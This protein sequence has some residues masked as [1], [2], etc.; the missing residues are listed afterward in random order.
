MPG[1]NVLVIHSAADLYGASK[2]LVR[3]LVAFQKIDWNPITILPNE[4][5]LVQEIK[6][7][8]LE[9]IILDHGVI[10]RQ[11]LSLKGI[12]ALLRQLA[13]SFKILNRLM[14]ERGVSLIYTNSN[15]NVV[16]GLLSRWTNTK[17]IWHVHEII[18][19]PKWFKVAL[20]LYNRFFGDMLLCVSQAVIDNHPLTPKSKL[21]LLYNGIDTRPFLKTASNLKQELGLKENVILIGMVARVSFWKGQKYFLDVASVL[22]KSNPNLHFIMVG[23][24]FT[25]Y[26]YLYEENR[27][28]L[29]KLGLKDHV[30]DLGFR[31]DITNI[32]GGLDIFMLPSIL[33]DP[34]PTTVLEAMA[35]GKPVVATSH[36][37][38]VE[39]VQSGETGYLVPWDNAE[40]AA[41]SFQILIDSPEKRLVMGEKGAQRIKDHFS[42]EKY[43]A[44]FGEIISTV[45]AQKS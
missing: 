38:A 26:E 25:G 37:G 41:A 32:L 7:L 11:N 8:G 27:A 23:D 21:N 10:R 5:P 12:I 36:G 40:K 18:N 13:N 16:G 42:I 33:P 19:H 30:T 31:T 3:S 34:L 9:V 22:V 1:K 45:T 17:H 6:N 28:H 20:E 35:A 2:N 4:G 15:A 39:M 24:A 43:I 44:N 14:K 29:E